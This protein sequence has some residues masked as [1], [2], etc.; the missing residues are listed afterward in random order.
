MPG[1]A[2]DNTGLSERW[3]GRTLGR[4]NAFFG[5]LRAAANPPKDNPVI[6]MKKCR[7]CWCP[8]QSHSV[9]VVPLLPAARAI[10]RT[11]RLV[12]RQRRR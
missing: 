5:S 2:Q 6:G 10:C 1:G 11:G 12:I 7:L 9:A 8:Y 3:M 4:L